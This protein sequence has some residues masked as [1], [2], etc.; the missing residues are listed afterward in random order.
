MLVGDT[1]LVSFL[2]MKHIACIFVGFCVIFLAAVIVFGGIYVVDNYWESVRLGAATIAAVF[3]CWL[4]GW[5]V[6]D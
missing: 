6:V 5:L 2:I 3:L 1:R 4:I